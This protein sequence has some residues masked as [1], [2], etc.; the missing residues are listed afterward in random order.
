[1]M[2]VEHPPRFEP[3]LNMEPKTE[4]FPSPEIKACAAGEAVRPAAP[5]RGGAF[6]SCL[7]WQLETFL[8]VGPLASANPGA[9]RQPLA[10]I[11]EGT[12]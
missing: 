11:Q 8:L 4:R 10:A 7:T 2:K 3:R 6:S 9:G 1:M 5:E 12:C